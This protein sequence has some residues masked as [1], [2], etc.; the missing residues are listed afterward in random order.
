MRLVFISECLQK[1]FLRFAGA[2]LQLWEPSEADFFGLLFGFLSIRAELG[3]V[4]IVIVR[5][6]WV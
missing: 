2:R 6:K 3:S 1:S 5:V 4:Y